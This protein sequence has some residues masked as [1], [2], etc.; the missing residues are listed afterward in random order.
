MQASGL[1]ARELYC[2]RGERLLFAGV[3]LRLAHGGA[4]RVIGPNGS[5]K[6]SLLRMLAGLLAPWPTGGPPG[7]V[8]WQGSVALLDDRLALDAAMPLEQALR[9]WADLD[10]VGADALAGNCAR[11]VLTDLLDVPVRYLSAGQKKRAALARL[12]GQGAGN[13]LLDE[14]LNG[15]DAQGIALVEGVIAEHRTGGGT[16]VVATHQP[17]DLPGA[18]VL[19]LGAM[20]P[21]V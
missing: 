14:P 12:L 9:F 13:W 21:A 1:T 10:E 15:L 16:C 4:L 11:L 20:S 2:R 3:D 8:E 5:G 17:I 6:T 18:A 7:T 19:D